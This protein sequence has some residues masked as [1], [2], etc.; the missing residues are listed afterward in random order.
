MRKAFKFRLYPNRDQEREMLVALET[1][2]RLYNDCLAQ[3]K[4][5]YE[6]HGV[7]VSYYDQCR[8]LTREKTFNKW[9]AKLGS[10]SAQATIRKLDKAFKAFF[11]RVASGASPG[12]PRFK[13]QDRFHSI[14]FPTYGDGVGL[15]NSRLRIRHVGT[16]KIK[17]HRPIEGKIKTATL[18]REG[19]KWFVVF[20]CDLG[21]CQ[22]P[23]NGQ[24]AIGIDVG[25]TAYLTTSDG[26]KEPNPRYLKREL[27]VLRRQ[28][29][30]VSRKQKGGKN[31]KKAVRRLR[32][33]H[34][35]IRNLRHDHRHKL[36]LDLCRRY[37]FIAVEGLNIKGML[38]NRWMSRAIA[39]AAWGE[40][41]AT[42]KYKAESAGAEVVEVN[43]KGTSQECSDCGQEVKKSLS[44]RVHRCPHCGLVL[45]RDE[46]AARNILAR[47]L[48]ARAGPAGVNSNG[49][50][51]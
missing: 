51:A 27:P 9:Y 2:R 28:S 39:D 19:D 34:T 6:E 8:W 31:R 37:G 3:R 13:A 14:E 45:N 26:D 30:A 1:H 32:T 23:P 35:K 15:K 12:H 38:G 22:V 43:P 25:L 33:V 49:A 16:I 7:S 17:Q 50:V 11:R 24:P 4:S 18:K 10:Q 48:L 44:V 36:S 46:N 21:V 47:A 5:A 41:L 20:S 42:L 40:F 29:R